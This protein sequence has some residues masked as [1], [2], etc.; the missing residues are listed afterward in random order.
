MSAQTALDFSG[1]TFDEEF[2]L[3]RLSAQ[4]QRVAMVMRDEKWRTLA[5]IQAITGDPESSIS[6][7][8]RDFRKDKWGAHTVNRRRRGDPKRGLYE[9]QLVLNGSGN[10]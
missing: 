1:K 4:M 6:A 7:R 5:E 10:V 8:L 9:Y 3:E 2:D